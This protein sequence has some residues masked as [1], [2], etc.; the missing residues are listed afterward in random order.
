[1]WWH[2]NFFLL[3]SVH[4][5]ISQVCPLSLVFFCTMSQRRYCSGSH[6]ASRAIPCWLLHTICQ[7]KTRLSRDGGNPWEG[8]VQFLV[9]V[10]AWDR[11]MTRLGFS[12]VFSIVCYVYH[13]HKLESV[14]QSLACDTV[15]YVL[16]IRYKDVRPVVS[17]P[18]YTCFQFFFL[19]LVYTK[20]QFKPPPANVSYIM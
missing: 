15:P 1:M 13:I 9:G 5:C 6:R 8:A 17:L 3:V 19:Y 11:A 4:R 7:T 2:D 14:R 12:A 18:E 10:T 16:R 20:R